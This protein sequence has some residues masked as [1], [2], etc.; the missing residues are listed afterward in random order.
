M[1]IRFF[2]NLQTVL[3]GLVYTALIIFA[4]L[5]SKNISSELL[6]IPNGISLNGSRFVEE[7]PF[8][9]QMVINS[10]VDGDT[11]YVPSG[12]YI[13]NIK[14]N[15]SLRLIAN[16]TVVIIP[17]KPS[18]NVL[19]ILKNNVTLIGFTIV[20][21]GGICGIYVKG[22]MDYEIIENKVLG[23]E[24]GLMIDGSGNGLL[25]ENGVKGCT[26]GIYLQES[27]KNILVRNNIESNKYGISLSLC[28]NNTI[29][30]NRVI[31]CTYG[32]Y[33]HISDENNVSK[34]VFQE[35]T[36]G[37]SI[38]R[39]EINLMFSNEILYN[40]YGVYLDDARKSLVARNEV[41]G[42]LIGIRVQRSQNIDI[43]DN[44]VRFSTNNVAIDSSHNVT[45]SRNILEYAK[46][47]GITIYETTNNVLSL[48]S[49]LSCR[50]GISIENSLSAEVE[51]NL[52]GYNSYGLYLFRSSRTLLIDNRCINN[53]ISDFYSEGSEEIIVKN[54]KIDHGDGEKISFTYRGDISIK[55]SEP[56]EFGIE[57]LLSGFFNITLFSSDS[58]IRINITYSLE[59]IRDVQKEEPVLYHWTG[60]ERKTLKGSASEEFPS[61]GSASFLLT[62]SG[63][64]ALGVGEK[65][66][67]RFSPVIMISSFSTLVILS[68]LALKTLRGKRKA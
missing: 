65:A 6:S 7:K 50:V 27:F 55:G 21:Q 29:I 64:Y 68:Y 42:G 1:L 44:A 62:E 11:I 22:V 23:G 56:V 24:F 14:I 45:V 34:N 47:H 5:A 15:K 48:N 10:A 61:N 40:F 9:I 3:K 38:I 25:M 46:G 41:A 33:S 52:I 26:F 20:N 51:N 13:E 63:I 59:G 67:E 49:I 18:D 19:E 31:N 53:T 43:L 17:I 30:E 58:W 28:S 32:F 2:K 8:S 54:L 37:V 66:P 39:S 57:R 35:N 36:V 16:G 4:M 60:T 12:T